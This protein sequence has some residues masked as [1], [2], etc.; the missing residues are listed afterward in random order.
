[1][2]GRGIAL[3]RRY[4]VRRHLEAGVP[5][6]PGDGFVDLGGGLDAGLAAK[7]RAKPLAHEVL[8]FFRA[9]IGG[10]PIA[11]CGGRPVRGERI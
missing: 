3:G 2:S 6:A 1:M 10:G 11:E 4:L 8:A 7:G 5:V 9:A